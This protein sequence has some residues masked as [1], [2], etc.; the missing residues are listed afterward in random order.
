MLT[1]KRKGNIFLQWMAAFANECSKKCAKTKY[2][3]E[4]KRQLVKIKS[5]LAG[6]KGAFLGN[7]L[8]LGHLRVWRYVTYIISKT[9]ANK[10]LSLFIIAREDSI[11]KNNSNLLSQSVYRF[12]RKLLSIKHENV[13]EFSG[14]FSHVSDI[15]IETFFHLSK[16]RQWTIIR[17]SSISKPHKSTMF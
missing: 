1:F 13:H 2:T 9:I 5:T 11:V 6:A 17:T 4:G 10:Y 7:R 14:G 16:R 12:C 3:Q 15:N 8:H